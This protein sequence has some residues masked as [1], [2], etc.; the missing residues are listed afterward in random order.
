MRR[1]LGDSTAAL[2]RHPATIF[3]AMPANSPDGSLTARIQSSLRRSLL[4]VFRLTLPGSD[5][6]AARLARLVTELESGGLSPR[7]ALGALRPQGCGRSA[8]QR[9]VHL[10][11]GEDKGG[12]GVGFMAVQVGVVRLAGHPY[13]PFGFA[14]VSGPVI[15]PPDFGVSLEGIPLPGVCRFRLPGSNRRMIPV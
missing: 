3:G 2:A 4:H 13:Q 15:G 14:A 12:L 6:I 10:G 7:H 5:L 9:G 1:W 11:V 8:G